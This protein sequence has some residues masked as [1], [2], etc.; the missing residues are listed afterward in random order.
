[1]GADLA[2]GRL[3]LADVPWRRALDRATELSRLYTP[4]LGTRTLDV[5]HVAS[6]V[7]LGCRSLVTYDE[8][9][10]AIADP[11]V[12][13]EAVRRVSETVEQAARRYRGFNFFSDEDVRLFEVVLRGEHSIQGF[14]NAHIR[15]HLPG[16]S[17]GQISRMLKRLRCHG[18]VKKVGR[19][20]KYYV[21]PAGRSVMTAGLKL[22]TTA[23]IPELA[24]AMAA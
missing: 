17:P 3:T 7:E 8:R 13:I 10:A 21:T 4:K 2:D 20:Y 15:G 18:L 14:R 11:T 12:A 16:R 22:K 19:T 1:M 9:Q 23:L 6:A 24:R 5:L